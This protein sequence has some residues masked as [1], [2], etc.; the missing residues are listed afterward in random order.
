VISKVLSERKKKSGSYAAKTSNR[1]FYL[2]P[3]K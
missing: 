2:A 3:A 1:T